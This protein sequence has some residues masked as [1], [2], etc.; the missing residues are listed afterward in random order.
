M[1]DRLP[2]KLFED[3]YCW[4]LRLLCQTRCCVS[5]KRKKRASHYCL[6]QQGFVV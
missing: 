5:N 4:Q 2:L 1:I 3:F 6:L